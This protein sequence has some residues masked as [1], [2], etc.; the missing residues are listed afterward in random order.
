MIWV[1]EARKRNAASTYNTVQGYSDTVTEKLRW[2]V[3]RQLVT[4]PTIGKRAACALAGAQSLAL[5]Y[6]VKD[7]L[8]REQQTHH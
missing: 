4:L 7:I 5:C 1:W 8:P 6:S 2:Q 3:L